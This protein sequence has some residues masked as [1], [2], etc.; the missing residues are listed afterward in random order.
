LKVD[1]ISLICTA[2]LPQRALYPKRSYFLNQPLAI[3]E[4]FSG[5]LGAVEQLAQ[6]FATVTGKGG[7]V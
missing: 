7:D 6:R 3:S 4:P 1:K 2:I 5:I